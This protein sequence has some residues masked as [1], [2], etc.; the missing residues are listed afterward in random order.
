[1]RQMES[2]QECCATSDLTSTDSD[3]DFAVSPQAEIHI[4]PSNQSDVSSKLQTS[5]PSWVPSSHGKRVTLVHMP[6]QICEDH[7]FIL[8]TN[9]LWLCLRPFCSSSKENH[10]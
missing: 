9:F 1:M 4:T 6:Q 3:K 8:M 7:S 10:A 5:A 2:C